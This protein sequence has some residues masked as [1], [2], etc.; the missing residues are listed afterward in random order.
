MKRLG[1]ITLEFEPTADILRE[2]TSLK[3]PGTLVVGFAAETE[4]PL[5]HGR[6]KL[7][8]K[9]A[10]AIVL[11]DVSRPGLGF[12]SDRNAATFLTPATAIEFPAMSKRELA[13]RVL[14]EVVALRRPQ[15]VVAETVFVSSSALERD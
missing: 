9:G 5:E 6:D 12:D 11:N 1:P 15:S 10:D 2:V 8:R 14:G 3:R 7:L 4:N 13:D